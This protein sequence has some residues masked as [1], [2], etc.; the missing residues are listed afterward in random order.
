[1]ASILCEPDR[2]DG[3]NQNDAGPCDV[4]IL[5]ER[6]LNPPDDLGEVSD[7]HQGRDTCKPDKVPGDAR[8]D[9][10]KEWNDKMNENQ[11]QGE[12]LPAS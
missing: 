7:N 11:K 2:P 3:H 4:E 5:S 1:M 9:Q 6:W 8:K 10:T 12:E